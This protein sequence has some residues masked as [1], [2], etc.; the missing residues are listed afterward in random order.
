ML[1]I[2]DDPVTIKAIEWSIVEHAFD[3]GW[4]RPQP[5]ATRTGQDGGRGGLGPRRSRRRPAAEPRRPSGDGVRARRP[6]RRPAP[7]RHPRVQDGKARPRPPARA[8]GGRGRRVQGGLPRRGRSRRRRDP[9]LV[10]RGAALRGRLR[11]ARPA[12]PRARA[13]PAST[14]PCATSPSRIA[15]ARETPSPTSSSSARPGKRVVII[16]GGDTGADCLGTVHRQGA[17]SVHQFEI[18]PR[19]PD[20]RAPENP[21]PLWPNVYRVSSAHEEGGERVY[22]VS[23]KRFAGDEAGPAQ[24][25]RGRARR[26]G[27]GGRA[28]E[29][30]GDRGIGLRPALRAGAPGDGVHRARAARHAVRARRQAHRARQPSGAT[31]AG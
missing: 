15:A 31:S 27:A 12:H 9:A 22:A 2:N 3:E 26:A 20:Q 25:P 10:R 30:Q 17:L 8:D 21:W 16:G 14:T 13:R 11:A 5:P 6:D 18:L 23:T 28:H 19:P 4:I 29:L 7:L 24:G 1:G